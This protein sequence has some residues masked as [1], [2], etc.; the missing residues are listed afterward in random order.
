[1]TLSVLEDHSPIVC[2]FKYDISYL[3]RI[4]WSLYIYKASCYSIL[5]TLEIGRHS[6]QI[7][8]HTSA[9][10]SDTIYCA[11]VHMQLSMIHLIIVT[12]SKQ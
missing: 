3:W 10:A 2:L 6:V 1:M 8:A 4:L 9:L 7:L 5:T 11:T 12:D